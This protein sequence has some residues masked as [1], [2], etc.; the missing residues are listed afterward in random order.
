M[1]LFPEPPPFK[2]SRPPG[3]GLSEIEFWSRDGL[4][5]EEAF[6]G[7]VYVDGSVAKDGHPWFH[8]PGWA[9]VKV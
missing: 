6:F 5:P 7:E 3:L 2:V 4:T 1:L 8:A 9:V